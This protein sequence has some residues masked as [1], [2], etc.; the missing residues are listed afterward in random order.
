MSQENVELAH[1]FYDAVNTRDLDAWLAVTDDD[2]ELSSILVP[3]EGGYHGHDGFRRWW[4]NVFD[5]FPDYTIEV[6]EVRDLGT[7]TMAAIR[8]RGHGSASDAPIDQPL[9]QI[10]QWRD[11]RAVRVESFRTEAEALESVGLSE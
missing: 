8:L 3:V 11:G 9:S 2:A 10:I 1:R 4:E 5:T 6:G 7:V